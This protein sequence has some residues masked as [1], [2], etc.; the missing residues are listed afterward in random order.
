MV[1]C[2]SIWSRIFSK[3]W[4]LLLAF[5]P[6]PRI[7]Y[8]TSSPLSRCCSRAGY[9]PRKFRVVHPAEWLTQPGAL[10]SP[11]RQEGH[12]WD[13][14][15]HQRG[16]RRHHRGVCS[17]IESA[18]LEFLLCL[19]QV[20]HSLGM[21]LRLDSRSSVKSLWTANWVACLTFC[22]DLVCAFC[23]RFDLTFV[24][25]T[26]RLLHDSRRRW[27]SPLRAL[28]TLGPGESDLIRAAWWCIY[29]DDLHV[30]PALTGVGVSMYSLL[31]I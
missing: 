25:L 3:T 9:G 19:N 13:L 20:S 8:V 14:R 16:D 28:E 18:D 17:P 6:K 24:S 15:R 4:S 23:F 12:E 27:I 30:C 5:S 2:H 29:L 31:I 21:D 11:G 1:A 26:R 10:A 22:C 7:W